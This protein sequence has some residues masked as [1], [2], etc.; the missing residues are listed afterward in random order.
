MGW[1][2]ESLWL[3]ELAGQVNELH[4]RGLLASVID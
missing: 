4:S 3:A 2:V 1:M